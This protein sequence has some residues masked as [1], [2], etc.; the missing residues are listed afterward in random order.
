MPT[1][2]Q[3]ALLDQ[4]SSGDQMPVYSGQ[5]GDARRLPISALLTYFQQTFAAPTVATTVYVPVT[6]FSIAIPTPQTEI[7]WALL[8]PAGTLATGTIVLPLNTA[9]ADGTEILMT[10]TQTITSLTVSLNGATAAS[11]AP[12]T[13]TAGSFAKLRFYQATNSWYRVG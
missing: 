9:V 2:N 10:S 7:F 4:V 13:L 11:G 6:G 1:I 8:N 5:N 12:T 3:L